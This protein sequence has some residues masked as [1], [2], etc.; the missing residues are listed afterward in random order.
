MATQK[1]TKKGRNGRL[2]YAMCLEDIRL[3]TAVSVRNRESSGVL[4]SVRRLIGRVHAEG[5]KPRI[6]FVDRGYYVMPVI[7][8]LHAEGVSVFDTGHDFEYHTNKNGP[9]L[10][11]KKMTGQQRYPR[12]LSNA[13]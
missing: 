8:A 11:M 5:K 4:E 3:I 10:F 9:F 6:V 7:D 13:T 1:N 12:M 2:G